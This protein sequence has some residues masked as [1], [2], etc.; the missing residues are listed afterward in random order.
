MTFSTAPLARSTRGTDRFGV[1]DLG[2]AFQDFR[3][4]FFP[5]TILLLALFVNKTLLR[6]VPV[7][8]I[9]IP[10][11]LAAALSRVRME[12][13]DKSTVR[14]WQLI[15]LY[16]AVYSLLHYPL[17]PIAHADT[18]HI[19]L[20]VVL[21]IAWIVSLVSGVL[22]FRIPSLS[23]LPPSFLAWSNAMA[24]VIAGFPI[25]TFLDVQPL[26]EIA[27]CI[28]YGLLII[29]I[30]PRFNASPASSAA[31]GKFAALLPIIAIVIHLANYF[32]SFMAKMRLHGPFGAW[33]T[34]NNPAYIY[35]AALDDGHILF[36][37]FPAAVRFAYEL[38]DHLHLI[39]NFF[40]LFTQAAALIILLFPK[41]ALIWLLLL[42]DVMHLAILFISGANFWPW[43]FLNVII[44]VI[45]AS[46]DFC[47]PPRSLRLI[48]MGF[49][50]ISPLFVAVAR[51]GWFDTGANNKIFFQAVDESGKRYDVPPN[52]FTFYSYSL[53]HM[54]YGAP[55]PDGA[56][57]T[58]S[59]NGGAADYAM[60]QAGRSCHVAELVRPGVYKQFDAK[61]LSNFIR[62]Y[63][64]LALK[65][66]SVSG[67]FPYDFYP[68]HYYTPRAE[69]ADFR[70]LD[71]RRVVAYIYRRESVCLSFDA[72][73]P[74]RK[75]V[76]A[77]EFK[78]DLSPEDREDRARGN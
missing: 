5:F 74:Q 57:A 12:T 76:S 69:S 42:F 45:V 33:L 34:Q 16:S 35:L 38:T 8:W 29:R 14:L 43:I 77:A 11:L 2:L 66:I 59:P 28:G 53:G 40:V 24:G 73:G 63:H 20:Y 62:N 49:M 36:S 4:I 44:T 60:F 75:I 72:T 54:D 27:L 18:F 22:C 13:V 26:P 10:I 21:L 25:T 46:R 7:F 31:I 15:G 67:T 65:L 50:V 39:S 71:K 70:D 78:I 55:D 58:Q 47:L 6:F 30:Y 23:V 52:F 51:L 3:V 17:M 32:W 68:H 41:R 56:F 19:G 48:A 9:L 64:S 61:D 37:G 1:T